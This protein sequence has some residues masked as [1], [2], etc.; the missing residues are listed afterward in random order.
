MLSK[1]S[2]MIFN[3]A[4]GIRS[5]FPSVSWK[6]WSGGGEIGA[7]GV[8]LEKARSLYR[9]DSPNA[10]LGSGF[11]KPIIDTTVAFMGLPH[12]VSGTN[13]DEFVN[14]AIHDHWAES[15]TEMLRNALRDSRTVVRVRRHV[16]NPLFLDEEARFCFLEVLDPLSVQLIYSPLDSCWIEKAICTYEI[17]VEEEPTTNDTTFQAPVI[18]TETIKEEITPQSFRYWNE[19]QGVWMDDLE[20][21]NT[22]G[23]V[24]L[25][26]VF[27]E[28]ED[29]LHGGQSDLEAPLPFL[30]AHHEVL[31]QTLK[32]HKYH[33]IPKAKFKVNDLMTF[34]MNNF[35]DSFQMGTDGRPMPNTFTGSVSWQGQEII[36]MQ[37][38][39]DADFLEAKSVLGDSKTLLEF[40]FDCICI[41]SETPR[42][43]FM[44]QTPGEPAQTAEGLPLVKKIDRKRVMYE[45]PIQMLAKMLLKINGGNPNALPFAWDD[46]NPQDM[47]NKAQALQQSTAAVEL[48]LQRRLIS[49]RTASAHLKNHIPEMKSVDQERRDAQDNLDLLAIVP[50]S[51]ANGGGA[52]VAPGQQGR[53]E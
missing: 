14:E 41:S 20:M 38:D 7:E 29:Y 44:V 23:F 9:N 34:L 46:V 2:E 33:S 1:I 5:R 13:D 12:A 32:A 39:E 30:L 21:V 52:P 51:T 40:L 25:V 19:T 27:N 53:N 17:E 24:P 18:T 11:A 49:D 8:W 36:F 26:E 10:S 45:K 48:A 37:P 15:L 31:S 42:W 50:N 22:W 6:F 16:G 35:P 3:W 28:W 47:I 4:G 43:A